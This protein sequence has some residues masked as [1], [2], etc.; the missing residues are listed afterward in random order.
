MGKIKNNNEIL[1]GGATTFIGRIIGLGLGYLF[2]L[3]IARVYGKEVVGMFSLAFTILQIGSIISRVGLDI[4]LMKL[5]AEKAVTGS[6]KEILKI[7]LLINKIA[8]PSSIISALLLFYF[9]DDLANK[10]FNNSEMVVILKFSA[11]GVLPLTIF[12]IHREGIRGFKKIGLYS[13]QQ[14]IL[15]FGLSLILFG[16]LIKGEFSITIPF[17]AYVY[18]QVILCFGSIAVWFSCFSKYAFTNNAESHEEFKALELLKLSVP[19]MLA[20]SLSLLMSWVDILMLG[21][22]A[23]ESEVGIYSVAAKIAALLTLPLY[24]VNSIAAPKFAQYWKLH[25]KDKLVR[26][27]KESSRLIFFSSV[28]IFIV[29]LVAPEFFLG[30]FGEDFK[31]G[32]LALMILLFGQMTNAYCGS[33]GNFLQMTGKQKIFQYILLF[34][35]AINIL[36][37]ALLIPIYGMTGAAIASAISMIIWNAIAV[38]YIF[39]NYGILMLARW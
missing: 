16:I 4:A 21:I 26:V 22:Y 12:S 19:L 28:P 18:S 33:V 7:Y 2:I 38:V 14:N 24:A 20:S 10:I 27:V 25:E 34:S 9:A 30:L 1:K 39:R 15:P 37:N 6:R 35:V 8:L 32:A 29:I 36:L 31:S 17:E 23:S 5:V 11:I 3:W 13:L